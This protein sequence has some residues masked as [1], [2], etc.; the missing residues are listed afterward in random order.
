MKML[1]LFND[2][3]SGW[4]WGLIMLA[5]CAPVAQ[6]QRNLLGSTSC[7][8]FQGGDAL[9]LSLL[10]ANPSQAQMASALLC[11]ADRGA[12]AGLR[13]RN[14][15]HPLL[16]LLKAQRDKEREMDM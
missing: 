11:L 5:F 8:C 9:Y 3:N 14:P 13:S 1:L 16:A 6:V 15:D 2:T 4:S 7:R 12:I 10:F